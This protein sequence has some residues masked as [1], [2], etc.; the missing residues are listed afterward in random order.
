M[1]KVYYNKLLK[2]AIKNPC[3]YTFADVPT[4]YKAQ[5]KAQA[6]ED[7][8]SGKLPQWQYNKMFGIAESEQESEG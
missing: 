1:W 8:A 3:T 4:K 5:V 7:L 2:E 6:D